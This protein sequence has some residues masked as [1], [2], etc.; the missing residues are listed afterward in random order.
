MKLSRTLG[1]SCNTVH[2]KEFPMNSIIFTSDNGTQLVCSDFR[3]SRK[4]ELRLYVWLPAEKKWVITHAKNEYTEMIWDY[5]RKYEHKHR[6][7]KGNY[8]A[9]MRH[10]RKHKRSGGGSKNNDKVFTDYECT[11]NPFHDFRRCYS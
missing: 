7:R 1:G 10:D 4:Q 2:G 9:F 5:Y 11:K 6:I 8:N 3:Q